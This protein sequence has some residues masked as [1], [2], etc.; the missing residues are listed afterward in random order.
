MNKTKVKYVKKYTNN[1]TITQKTYII[2]ET[3]VKY[4][5]KNIQKY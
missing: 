5:Q 3:V 4:I 2:S 1:H